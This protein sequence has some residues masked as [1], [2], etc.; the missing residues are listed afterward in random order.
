MD[1]PLV[2]ALSALLCY[3]LSDFVYK[4]SAV[5]GIRADHFLM[6]QGWFFC[7]LVIVYALASGRLHLVP[8]AAW[9]PGALAARSRPSACGGCCGS[10]AAS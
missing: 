7:P 5:A 9:P 1:Q 3:G 6:V 4:R 2:F 10:A 8:P